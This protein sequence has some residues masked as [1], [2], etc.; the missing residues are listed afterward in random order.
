VEAAVTWDRVLVNV[1]GLGLIGFIVWFFWL[2]KTEGV[3][4]A[5]AT[6][7][8]QEQMILVK[9][10]YTPDVLVVEAGKPVRLNFVRQES[11]S[12]SEMVLLP[13]FGKSAKLPEGETVSVEF[14][15]KERGEFEFACQMGM[16]RG[17][18]IVE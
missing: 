1:V 18:I 8:Y 17:K 6:S 16:I 10:G 13:A 14:L 3:R 5:A 15:P 9:G 12:C 2:K 11:A 4:V 7:G